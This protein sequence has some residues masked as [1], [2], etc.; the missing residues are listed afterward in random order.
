ML[1]ILSIFM[2]FFLFS[3]NSAHR[4]YV[5]AMVDNRHNSE[6]SLTLKLLNKDV[7]MYFEN[8]DI[9]RIGKSTKRMVRIPV[10]FLEKPQ[11]DQLQGVIGLS[12]RKASGQALLVD[13]LS[14]VPINLVPES[15]SSSKEGPI[16]FTIAP[17][18]KTKV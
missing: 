15:S 3:C 4:Y 2:F 12:V 6:I 1:F 10:I 17:E 11:P 5:Y 14:M 7:P 8:P 18:S 9:V 16:Q 13:G